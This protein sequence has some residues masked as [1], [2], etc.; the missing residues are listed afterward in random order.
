MVDAAIK[1]F[2]AK[3]AQLEAVKAKEKAIGVA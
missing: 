1:Q 2:E 3:R